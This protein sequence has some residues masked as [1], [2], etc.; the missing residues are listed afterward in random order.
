MHAKRSGRKPSARKKL[1]VAAYTVMG[2]KGLD[3]CSIVDII[4]QAG[5]G[6]GSFYNHFSSKEDLAKAVF[7]ERAEELGATLERVALMS[8]NI[9]AATCYAFRRLIEEVELDALWASFIVQLEPS[10][11]MLDGLLRDH[12]RIGLRSGVTSGMLS[13]SDVETGITAFHAVMVAVAKAMLAGQIS[14]GQAHRASL[15][16]LRMFGVQEAEAVRLS[17]LSMSELRQTLKVRSLG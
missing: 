4:E 14:S 16:G 8:D 5:V 11:Q 10:M 12:A 1:I 15:F 9:A 7:A 6:V 2:A 3:G 13:I 17:S